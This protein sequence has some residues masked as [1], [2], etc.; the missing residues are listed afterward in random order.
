MCTGGRVVN[1]LKAF[2]GRENTDVVFV[3]YQ[4]TG[5]LGR[6]IQKCEGGQGKVWIDQFRFRVSFPPTGP[7]Q[8]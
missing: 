5:T 7:W 6:E 8:S 1:Y 3:G 4:G 2:L